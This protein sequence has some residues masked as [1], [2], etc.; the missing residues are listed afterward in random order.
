M[1]HESIV[2]IWAVVRQARGFELL[3]EQSSGMRAFEQPETAAFTIWLMT[4]IE[5]WL[6]TTSVLV[7]Q[8]AM[9]AEPLGIAFTSRMYR[10]LSFFRLTCAL[11][12]WQPLIPQLVPS[13]WATAVKPPPELPPAAP[14]PPL[15]PPEPLA[16]APPMVPPEPGPAP[17]AAVPPEPTPPP[18]EEPPEA[19]PPEPKA[20]PE[21]E[22]PEAEPPV[23]PSL[24]PEPVF[25][26]PEPLPPDPT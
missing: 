16:P 15:V 7:L 6:G 10:P 14:P 9:T 17:P 8:L 26:P 25:D 12:S 1:I 4:L 19:E 24:P 21:E 11:L 5:G 13:N 3:V 23:P 2:L 22:P 18:D 20:P